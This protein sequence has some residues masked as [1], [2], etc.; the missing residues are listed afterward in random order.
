V[1]EF[2]V[3]YFAPWFGSAAGAIDWHIRV[4]TEP[5][6]YE[7]LQRQWPS[8]AALQPCFAHDQQ[9]LGLPSYSTGD[10]VTVCDAERGCFLRLCPGQVEMIG[11]AATRRWRFTL[12]WVILEIAATQLRRRH[13][14][15]HAACVQGEGHGL[16]IAGAK[17]A[18]KT[19]L[20][21]YLMRSCG[22]E[23]VANDRSF[24]RGAGGGVTAFGMPTAVKIRPPTLAVFPELRRNLP[25]VARP[26]LYTRAELAVA[27]ASAEAAHDVDFAL[28]PNQ[29][30]A[31][32]RVMPRPTTAVS[33]IVFP[34]V[35]SARS[36]FDVEAMS[37]EAVAAAIHANL[38]GGGRARPPTLFEKWGAGREPLSDRSLDASSAALRGFRLQLGS[39]VYDGAALAE[40]LLQLLKG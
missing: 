24:V 39:G 31:R 3:E 10:V 13:V 6:D 29:L 28:T 21:L 36:G 33:A 12:V 16:L 32:L 11:S 19:S 26:Y 4:H 17:G 14:D 7:A 23:L 40:R 27:T 37:A 38:Y 15:L 8:D 25:P 34:E 9:T 22:A 20:T 35:C 18:G 2:V 5:A 30:A 1:I